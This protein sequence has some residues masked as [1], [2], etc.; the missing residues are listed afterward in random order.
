HPLRRTQI[1]QT[2]VRPGALNPAG[3]R[4]KL[5]LAEPGGGQSPNACFRDYRGSGECVCGSSLSPCDAASSCDGPYLILG[6]TSVF[7]VS[8]WRL[9]RPHSTTTETQRTQRLHREELKAGHYQ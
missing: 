4:L 9:G 2:P 8:L 1:R 3:K 6:A 7:S 5:R